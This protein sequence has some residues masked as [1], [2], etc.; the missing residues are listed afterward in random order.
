MKTTPTL[1][2]LGHFY[3]AKRRKGIWVKP[4]VSQVTE[5]DQLSFH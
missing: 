2:D 1:S 5:V 4:Q 3:H